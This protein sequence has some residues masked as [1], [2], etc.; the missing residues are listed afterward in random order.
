MATLLVAMDSCRLT[1]FTLGLSL[2]QV[3]QQL[4]HQ[5]TSLSEPAVLPLTTDPTSEHMQVMQTH[6]ST[7][8]MASAA[9]HSQSSWW[10]LSVPRQEELSSIPYTH[11]MSAEELLQEL[12]CQRLEQVL[13]RSRVDPHGTPPPRE[14]AGVRAP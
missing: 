6:Q 8:A 4:E 7:S 13:G 2:Q 14:F 5:W 12:L 9:S 10:R 1:A 3:L 11:A